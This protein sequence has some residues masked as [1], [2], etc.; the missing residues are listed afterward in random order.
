MLVRRAAASTRYRGSAPNAV[1]YA[2]SR[3]SQWII[4]LLSSNQGVSRLSF[5]AATFICIVTLHLFENKVESFV[6]NTKHLNLTS[7]QNA[8][9]SNWKSL[10]RNVVEKP[11]G[12]SSANKL[13][14]ADH[15]SPRRKLHHMRRYMRR[16]EY[17]RNVQDQSHSHIHDDNA[18]VHNEHGKHRELY[19]HDVTLYTQKGIELHELARKMAHF[20]KHKL[21]SAHEQNEFE[22]NRKPPTQASRKP[23][24]QNEVRR[25]QR[26]H[27][28]GGGHRHYRYITRR[29]TAR[30]DKTQLLELR[31]EGAKELNMLEQHNIDLSV[32]QGGF[33][34][35]KR[36]HRMIS[37][38]STEKGYSSD[39]ASR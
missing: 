30:Q 16:R 6:D 36:S 10:E 21:Q 34:S 3:D 23:P 18:Q 35:R 29:G 31:N 28:G 15:V 2:P 14:K 39:R 12:S 26:H 38:P 9:K 1:H 27:H 13:R 17:L 25:G 20:R 24:N 32:G 5:L 11:N 7:E 4:E 19:E 22:H 33:A 8:T 37:T